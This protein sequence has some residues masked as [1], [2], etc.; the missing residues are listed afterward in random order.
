LLAA[1]LLDRLV[2]YTFPLVLGRGKR[3]FGDGTPAATMTLVDHI[4]SPG[5]AV[6]ATYAPAG[7]VETGSFGQIASARETERQRRIK[8]G[9]W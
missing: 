6:I 3:L 2:T 5:G 1:G 4:V 8:E 9:A 7:V